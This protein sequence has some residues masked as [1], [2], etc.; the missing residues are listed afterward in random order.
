MIKEGY[1]WKHIYIYIYMQG[2]HVI[3]FFF[4]LFLFFLFCYLGKTER[5]DLFSLHI[6]TYGLCLVY[7]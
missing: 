5:N 1:L 3:L 6:Q 7:E 2:L 4:F